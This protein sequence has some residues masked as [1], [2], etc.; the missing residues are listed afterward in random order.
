MNT[1]WASSRRHRRAVTLA[2]VQTRR[3]NYDPACPYPYTNMYGCTPCPKCREPYRCIF[4][5]DPETIVCD[6]CGHR[7]AVRRRR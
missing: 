2:L 7:A 5:R 4:M 1:S 6:D 3:W